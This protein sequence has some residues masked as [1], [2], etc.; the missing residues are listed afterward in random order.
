MKI[1]PVSDEVAR[2]GLRALQTVALADGDLS[3]LERS[4]IAAVQEHVLQS[5]VDL[6]ALTPIT[7]DELAAIV[8]APALRQR[9]LSGT[10]IASVIDGRATED[11][12]DVIAAFA[13]ALELDMSP[14]ITARRLAKNQLFLARIDLARRALPGHK[15]RQTLREDGVRALL[16]QIAQVF[17]ATDAA[18]AARYR[19]LEAS[20]E[21]TLGRGY[22]DYILANEFSFPG[23]KDSGPEIIVLHDCMHVIS[24]YGTTPDAEIEVSAFQ[25][26]CHG[27]DPLYGVLFGLAQYH[28]GVQVAPVAPSERMHADPDRLVRAFARGARIKRDMWSDFAPWDHFHKPLAELRAEL[29]VD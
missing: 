4:F 29:G 16:A 1:D 25:A 9:I 5:S 18:L 22:Y 21:G 2:A 10:V 3:P 12:V 19:A 11:E 20:P 15:L 14:V 6:D 24:G 8:Q 27:G 17:G 7:P 28:L 23:E 13:R 26:A